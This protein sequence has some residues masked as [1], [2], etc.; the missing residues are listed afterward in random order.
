MDNQ[1]WAKPVFEVAIADNLNQTN[2]SPCSDCGCNMNKPFV[3]LFN[4]NE[5]S[6][7]CIQTHHHLAVIVFVVYHLVWSCAKCIAQFDLLIQLNYI[8]VLLLRV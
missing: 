6:S 4:L 7:I 3:S 8:T 5:A 2:D 1:M